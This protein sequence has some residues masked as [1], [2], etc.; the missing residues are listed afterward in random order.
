MDNHDQ[1][2]LEMA[3][4]ADEVA[5]SFAGDSNDISRAISRAFTE[6]AEGI[7]ERVEKPDEDTLLAMKQ[8]YSQW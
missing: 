3:A 6:F 7:R 8:E 2:K 1:T 5:Q 4:A